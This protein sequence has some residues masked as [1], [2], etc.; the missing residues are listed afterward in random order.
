MALDGVRETFATTPNSTRDTCHHTELDARHVPPQR[1]AKLNSE[2]GPSQ[3]RRELSSAAAA[4][5][6]DAH[7]AHR[8]SL[9]RV[10]ATRGCDTRP[11]HVAVHSWW[12]LPQKEGGAPRG[13]AE[14]AVFT[15]QL[16]HAHLLYLACRVLI[17]VDLSTMSRFWTQ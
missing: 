1:P 13:E 5:A 6:A 9:R 2:R 15:R 8:L 3:Q 14:A 11:C 4:A 12:C 16:A 17:L 10:A 7:A